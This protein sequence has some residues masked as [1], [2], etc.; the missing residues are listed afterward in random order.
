[1]LTHRTRGSTEKELRYVEVLSEGEVVTV[2]TGSPIINF[3][4]KD[5]RHF[6]RIDTDR[7][8][9]CF[10]ELSGDRIAVGEP[11]QVTIWDLNAKSKKITTLE[12]GDVLKLAVSTTGKL[13]AIS[14]GFKSEVIVW[15]LNALK[16]KAT[17]IPYSSDIR[18]KPAILPNDWF[19]MYS[20]NQR[21]IEI[22]NADL[23]KCLP[24]TLEADIKAISVF[25]D[26]R[27]IVG[28]DKYIA[29]YKFDA[30]KATLTCIDKSISLV[31]GCASLVALND[32]KTFL[33]ADKSGLISKW[34]INAKKV[35]A[36]D[37]VGILP[38]N[39]VSNGEDIVC[40]ENSGKKYIQ[41][42]S[43]SKLDVA[44]VVTGTV[45]KGET[46]YVGTA[47]NVRGITGSAEVQV[48]KP[49]AP[50]PT[51][52]SAVANAG[53]FKK[54]PKKPTAAQTTKEYCSI[55]RCC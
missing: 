52:I 6:G 16:K 15:D 17:T 50:L 24:F 51:K 29:I 11:D 46:Q 19:I 22:R 21:K 14:S 44:K 42:T 10:V 4:K 48:T 7:P 3:W 26:G 1:M 47:G 13:I 9:R 55:K 33:C 27:V 31:N 43:D 30:A 20:N 38:V 34:D 53:I 49:A 2:S 23:T 41:L 40:Y 54:E 18:E 35:I 12:A 5:G 45:V 25:P 37:K 36:T 8:A 28:F 39:L 32:G